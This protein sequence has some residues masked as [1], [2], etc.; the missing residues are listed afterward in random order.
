MKYMTIAAVILML[1]LM[2]CTQ[3][4]EISFVGESD[5]WTGKYTAIIGESSEDGDF[6]FEYKLGGPQEVHF[7]N[8]EVYADDK[9]NIFKD[10]EYNSRRV[11]MSRSCSGCSVTRKEAE[12]LVKIKWD[13]QEES[14]VLKPQ[15]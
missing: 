7:S 1:L 9:K 14:F 13:G 11:T 4:E 10:E 3:S 6:I 15:S 12:L 8:L 5:H 2:G